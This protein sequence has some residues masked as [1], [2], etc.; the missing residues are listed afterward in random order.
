MTIKLYNT[1][2]KSVEELVPLR[3]GL[4]R[5]YSCGPTVYNHAHIGNMRSFLAA[6]LLQRVCR[7]V[8]LSLIHI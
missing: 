2:S 8:G 6:D 4:V 5:I 1:L 3:D 7:V